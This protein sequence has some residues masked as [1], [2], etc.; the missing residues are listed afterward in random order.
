MRE[1]WCAKRKDLVN[2]SEDND[3]TGVGK[4]DY[5]KLRVY[6]LQGTDEQIEVDVSAERILHHCPLSKAR[7][8]FT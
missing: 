5:V 8:K 7:S 2:G 6:Q 4:S 1:S 3:G